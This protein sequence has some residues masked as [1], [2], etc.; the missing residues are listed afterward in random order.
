MVSLVTDMKFLI[1]KEMALTSTISFAAILPL[2]KVSIN[3]IFSHIFRIF[4]LIRSEM[5]DKTIASARTIRNIQIV[6]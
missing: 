1:R 6:P 2:A 5:I 3:D 4:S